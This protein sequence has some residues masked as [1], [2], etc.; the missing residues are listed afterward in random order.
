LPPDPGR[1]VYL[2][3]GDIDVARAELRDR[4]VDVG[5]I[6]HKAGGEQWT[7]GWEPAVDPER[8]DYASFL[9]FTDPDGNHWVLQERGFP[10][11]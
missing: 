8:R 2:V 1:S 11:G 5:D 6:R 9:D 7:G 3:V 10:P 4:G